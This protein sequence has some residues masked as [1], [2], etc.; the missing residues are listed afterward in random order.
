[1]WLMGSYLMWVCGPVVF[2][3]LWVLWGLDRT[4]MGFVLSLM[5]IGKISIT[6]G[7]ETARQINLRAT[8]TKPACAGCAWGVGMVSMLVM[9]MWLCT[10]WL[11]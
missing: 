9:F 8:F 4:T 1:L 6:R 7:G 5:D 11:L 3:T 2:G 10:F